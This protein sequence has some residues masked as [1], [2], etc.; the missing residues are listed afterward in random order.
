MLKRS[1]DTVMMLSRLDSPSFVS[2]RWIIS[3]SHTCLGLIKTQ[4][5]LSSVARSPSVTCRGRGELY[6]TV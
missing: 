5:A 4:F 1:M 6:S 3:I 2:L